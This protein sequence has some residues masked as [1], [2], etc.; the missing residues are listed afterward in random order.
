MLA[1]GLAVGLL[2]LL[3]WWMRRPETGPD[4]EDVVARA[5][6]PS[7]PAVAGPGAPEQ[8]ADEPGPAAAGMVE[9]ELSAA[10]SRFSGVVIDEV[11]KATLEPIVRHEPRVDGT[12]IRFEPHHA[13]GLGWIRTPRHEPRV[14]GWID[15]ACIDLVE[16]VPLPTRTVS[17]L[18]HGQIEVGAVAVHGRCEEAASGFSGAIGVDGAFTLEVPSDAA[19]QLFVRR[20]FVEDELESDG[21]AIPSGD[22][23]VAGIELEVPVP[24]GNGL[25]LFAT[26][27]GLRVQDLQLGSEAEAAG[28]RPLD[29]IVAVDGE[30]A[31]TL[32]PTAIELLEGPAVLEVERGDE[33]LELAL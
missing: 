20:V 9:C 13:D 27:G 32:D 29:L 15:G 21:V 19:C 18:V 12:F 4:L 28:V 16:L 31:T 24:E 33:L 23:D 17:G 8:A 1:S 22:H 10:V 14:L 25:G 2:L 6:E 5:P 7:P 3:A 30:A 26:E 11:D